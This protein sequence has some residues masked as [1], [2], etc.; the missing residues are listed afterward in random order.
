MRPKLT[1]L[2]TIFLSIILI[3]SSCEKQ[4]IQVKTD[5]A[6][7]NT[8]SDGSVDRSIMSNGDIKL[9][10]TP[11]SRNGQ[12]ANVLY[13]EDHPTETNSNFNYQNELETAAW[14]DG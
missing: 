4:Q 11:N 6:I 7:Q 12:D 13:F 5:L 14:T 10:L 9:T 1:M 8:E 3:F 2:V